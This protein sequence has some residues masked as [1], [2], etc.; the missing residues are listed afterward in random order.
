TKTEPMKT[1]FKLLF[2]LAPLLAGFGASAQC[3]SYFYTNVGSGGVVYFY[4]SIN[5]QSTCH[6]NFGDGTTG[7][8][9]SFQFTHTY[10]S[11]GGYQVCLSATDHNGC[12]SSYCDSVFVNLCQGVSQFSYVQTGFGQ[13]SF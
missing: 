11:S 13:Y 12:T 7:N 5:F 8:D 4:D 6:W 1:Q 2:F 10:T 9:S 3:S